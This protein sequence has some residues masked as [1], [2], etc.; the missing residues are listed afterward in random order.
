MNYLVYLITVYICMF[1][2]QNFYS[3]RRKGRQY[4]SSLNHAQ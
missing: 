1:D 2:T 4:L 3:I